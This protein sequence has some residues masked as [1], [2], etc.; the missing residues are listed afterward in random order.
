MLGGA[1]QVRSFERVLRKIVTIQA[2]IGGWSPCA[3]AA[4][5]PSAPKCDP[6]TRRRRLRLAWVRRV[7]I[8]W[9]TAGAADYTGC[10]RGSPWCTALVCVAMRRLRRA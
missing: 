4:A 5:Q 9:E 7:T 8:K 10:C 3:R 1:P 2:G 6:E